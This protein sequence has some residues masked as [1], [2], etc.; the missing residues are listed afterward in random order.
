[1]DI[2][3]YPRNHGERERRQVNSKKLEA[4]MKSIAAFP[5]QS[6]AVQKGP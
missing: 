3:G 6:A 2:R 1:V 4:M 5:D